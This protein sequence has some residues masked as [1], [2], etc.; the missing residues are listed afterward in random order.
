MADSLGRW[1]LPFGANVVEGG[2]EFRV[3]APAS[4]SVE[5]VLGPGEE[6]AHP[7]ESHPDGWF[8]AVVPEVAAGASYRFRLDG[9]DAYPDPASRAQPEG[10]HGASA[11]VDPA[12]YP[13]EDD[14]WRGVPADALVIYELHVGTVTPAGTFDA[15]IERLD[16]IAALGVTAIEL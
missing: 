14:E 9:G 1:R 7:L 13:W 2:V 5:V 8:A 11:V 6:R 12:A 4:T 16:A 3:W 15:L 10:V